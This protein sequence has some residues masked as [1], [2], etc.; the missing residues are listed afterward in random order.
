MY[1]WPE[2]WE[3]RGWQRAAFF[4]VVILAAVYGVWMGAFSDGAGVG[5][6]LVRQHWRDYGEAPTEVRTD[7]EVPRYVRTFGVHCR[8]AAAH[9][10]PDCAITWH[11]DGR[12][13]Q[14]RCGPIDRSSIEDWL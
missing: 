14:R 6:R 9:V 12:I 10:A 2:F 13:R 5:C 4:T 7:A 3:L 11:E 8:P 1:E